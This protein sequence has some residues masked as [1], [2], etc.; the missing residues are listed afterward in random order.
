MSDELD[1][2]SML[3]EF[4]QEWNETDEDVQTEETEVDVEDTE[5]EAEVDTPE[6]E[7]ATPPYEKEEQTDVVPDEKDKQNKAFA[8]LRRQAQENQRFADFVQKLA[9]DSGLKPEDVLARYQERQ[10]EERSKQEG[11]PVEYLKRQND[12][13]TRLQELESQLVNER[14]DKQIQD[15]KQTYNATDEDITKTFEEMFASGVDPRITPNVNFEKF[16]K[17]ANFDKI[18]E[19]KVNES[20]Q[21]D[22]ASKKK[23]QQEAALPNGSSV[24]QP[25]N[26]LTDDEFDSILS[27]L[28]LKL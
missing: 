3:E 8:E 24:S 18:L 5:V 20:R 7:V 17:A 11:V 19:S 22:L 25:S 27:K 12:T 13:E 10:L 26:E 1:F 14:L 23:R 6:E 4:E 21:N 16:Y 15:V 2:D 28:D 9:E